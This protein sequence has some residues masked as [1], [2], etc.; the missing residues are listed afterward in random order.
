[1]VKKARKIAQNFQNNFGE[2][3]SV[4]QLINE[5]SNF[6]QEFTHS[7]GV[8]PFGVSIFIIGFDN[9][10]PN[11]F[12]VNPSGSFFKITSG[13]IGKN[14]NIAIDFLKRRWSK[15]LEIQDCIKLGLI[16]LQET[17]DFSIS[18][19]QIH[20]GIIDK[21]CIFY[22]LNQKQIENFIETLLEN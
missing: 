10:G 1:M 17:S 16:A 6:I 12:Q 21:N 9:F 8:R 22:I 20:I 19:N 18:K 5:L 14:S 2:T 4:K 13:G 7:G 15:E 11:L 3:I